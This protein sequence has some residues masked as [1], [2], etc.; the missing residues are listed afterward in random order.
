MKMRIRTK[1]K[2]FVCLTTLIT[3][4]VGGGLGYFWAY[5]LLRDTVGNRHS[6]MAEILAVS[7]SEMIDKTTENIMALADSPFWHNAVTENNLEYEDMDED[8]LQRYLWDM[9]KKWIQAPDDSPLIKEYLETPLSTRLRMLAKNQE[10]IAEIFLTNKVGGLVASSGRTSDFYQADEAWWQKSLGDGKG[11]VFVGNIE[12]DKSANLLSIPFVFPIKD[13]SGEAVGVCKAVISINRF[14]EPLGR[15]RIGKTGHV[16]LTNEKSQIIFHHGIEPLTIKFLSDEHSKALSKSKNERGIISSSPIHAGDMLVA[17]TDVKHPLLLENGILWKIWVNQS[18]EEVFAPLDKLLQQGEMVAAILILVMLPVAFIFGGVFVKPINKLRQAMQRV[19]EGNLDLKVSTDASDEIGELSRA[20][21]QMTKDL[22][23]STTSITNLNKEIAE[24]ERT[25]EALFESEQKFRGLFEAG[26]DAI[27]IA[28]A[29]T[30]KLVDC[31][32]QAEELIGYPREEILSM[33][34]DQLHPKDKLKETMEGFKKQAVGEVNFVESEILT[35]DKKRVPVSISSAPVEL[36]GRKCVQGH[37]RDVTEQRRAEAAL[38]NAKREAEAAAQAKSEFLANM[39]HEIRT[40]MNAVIGMTDLALGTNLATEQREYLETVKM[41]ADSL[42]DLLNN[43]LDFSKIE[44]GR[45]EPEEINFDL[46]STVESAAEMLAVKAEEA[47]LELTCHI[48][49]DVPT[50]L[51]GDPARIRQIIVNLT[52]NAIKFTEQGQVLIRVETE[53]EE[54]SSVLLHFTLWDTGIG[55]SPDKVKTIFEGF[56][57]ADGSTTRQ[58]GGT[59]LGLTISKQLVEMMGG[60]MWVESPTNSGMWNAECGVEN[61][62]S[63]IPG[64]DCGA[65][66][67]GAG[68]AGQDRQSKIQNPKSKIGGPGS[69]FH[70]TARF[71]L[72]RAK[73]EGS[74][75][76]TELDLSG[77]PV[78]IVDDNATN[79]LVLREMTSSW[80]LVPT[81]VADGEG[82]LVKMKKAFESGK[83]YRLLLVD[84]QMPGMGGFEVTKKVKESA[85]GTDIQIIVLTS[86]GQKGDAARCKALG[87]SGY[88]VKPVKQSELLD[89]IV[90][91][92]GQ[93]TGEKIPVITRHTIQEARRRLNL[94]LAEDNLVNQ[95]VAVRMLEKRGHRVVVAPNGKKA[96]EALDKESFDLILMDVQ[97]PEM[98][99]IAATRK[100]RNSKFEI[101]N[102]PIV[103][104]TAHALRGDR[105]RCL[106]A[107]MDDYISKP[108]KAEELFRVIEKL[109]DGS[110]DKENE[111]FFPSSIE[112]TAKDVFDLSKALEVM[113]GDTELFQEIANLFI[114]NLPHNIAQIREGITKSDANAVE[115]AAHGLKGSISNFGAKRAFEAAYGL[116]RMGKD[117]RLAEAHPALSELER[118]LK[119]LEAAMKRTLWEMKS[120]GSNC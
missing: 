18:A 44:A 78:L 10:D 61:G 74:P 68:R 11:K 25:E 83:P 100:I 75:R 23:K 6:E 64:P 105:E 87:I 101:R 21:E 34:A 76:L 56:R 7:V 103:A 38:Q 99:G 51:V 80:G 69:T 115:R 15:F 102:L 108:I 82:A 28:D 13:S 22:R 47:G 81:E 112:S 17:W 24:R 40:P 4:V 59:G 91:A 67:A 114:G 111:E 60:E 52:G 55:V 104:M 96:M 117:G 29:E 65:H 27:F 32:R 106:A 109:A 9:D 63:E 31:N 72:N 8:A 57:Q 33:Y 39:S 107:G 85:Y 62:R 120:E 97:M 16:F 1:I 93:R 95:E 46:R 30:R 86:V 41:S 73:V 79:R 90:M 58:Y 35:K 37:F 71:A 54:D 70:F 113:V 84:M 43:I 14:F 45:L 12:F 119:A 3:I 48:K 26:N 88:L 110:Q 66:R 19:A 89:A 94:L 77:M 42:L 116:E 20:F 49:P 118:E 5:S 50:A 36:G 98:D 53:K 2:L 92:I